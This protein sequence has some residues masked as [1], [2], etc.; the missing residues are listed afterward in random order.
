[1]PAFYMSNI[2]DKVND[3]E[4]FKKYFKEHKAIKTNDISRLL[5]ACLPP[6]V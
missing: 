2:V 5:V 4:I 3:L 1:M 6:K